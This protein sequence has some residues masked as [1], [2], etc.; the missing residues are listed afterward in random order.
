MDTGKPV[1][2]TEGQGWEIGVRR[3]FPIAQHEAWADLL[4]LL[5]LGALRDTAAQAGRTFTLEAGRT[6]T[7]ADGTR[8]EV[9]SHT[10]GALLRM[11]WQPAGWANTSTLQL[12]A[13]AAKTGTTLSIHHERLADAGQR[14][15]MRAHW[16]AVLAGL[17]AAP[18]SPGDAPD[19]AT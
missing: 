2:L 3:T 18:R 10:P 7:L 6:F 15:A 16:A 11:R 12:R 9:R 8:V 14:E 13:L 5:G 19:S 17:G 1:G 4:G